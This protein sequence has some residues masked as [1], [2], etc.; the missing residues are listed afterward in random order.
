MITFYIETLNEEKNTWYR[1]PRAYASV[2]E[3]HQAIDLLMGMREV[4][5]FKIV[6]EEQP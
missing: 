1:L 6:R 5:A 3:L 2:S 4:N